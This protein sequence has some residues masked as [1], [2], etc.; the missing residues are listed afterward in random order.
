MANTSIFLD[1]DI[2]INWLGKEIDPET[3]NELW[4][5]PHKIL[6]KIESRELSGFTPIINLMEIVLS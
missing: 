2:L 6:K 1:T 4:Q 3:G 5:A